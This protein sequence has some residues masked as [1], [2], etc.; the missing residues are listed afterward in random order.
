MNDTPKTNGKSNV[1]FSIYEYEQ[2]RPIKISRSQTFGAL[3]NL[4][5]N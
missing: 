1:F 4:R 2:H 5:F 3:W